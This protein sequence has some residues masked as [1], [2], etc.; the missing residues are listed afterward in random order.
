M[1]TK[2]IGINNSTKHDVPDVSPFN[3]VPPQSISL[4]SVLN[5]WPVEVIVDDPPI[6]VLTVFELSLTKTPIGSISFDNNMK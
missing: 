6:P 1:R 2:C 3:A 5:P 4:S